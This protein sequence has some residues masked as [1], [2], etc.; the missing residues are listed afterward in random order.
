[1]K[2]IYLQSYFR[3]GY[4]RLMNY[5]YNISNHPKRREIEKR[6]EIIKFFDE[7]GRE[8]TK[9]AFRKSRSTI[10]LWKQKIKESGGK[11]SALAPGDT[12]PKTR[13][14][15]TQTEQTVEFVKNYRLAHPGSDKVTIKPVIDAYCAQLSIPTVSESTIGRIIKKLKD[16]GQIP[17]YYIRTTVNG[18]TG[19]LLFR[20]I[21]KHKIKKLRSK[22]YRPQAPGD[23]IQIDAISFFKDGIK[24]Y[25]IC[26]LDI[27]SRFAFAYLYN[28]LSSVS[29]KDFVE[30][31][32][33]VAPF[34][35]R[36]VQTDNGSEF[37]KYF[38]KYLSDRNITHYWN[39][40]K[41]PK[42]NAFVERFNGVIQKQYIGWHLGDIEDTNAFNKGLME[43][44]IWYNT[45]KVH[46]AIGKQPPLRYFINTFVSPQ[47]S[48]MLWTVT[49]AAAAEIHR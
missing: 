41:Y 9:Q 6:L 33:D 25:C 17:D 20:R 39:Y 10:F 31:I 22:R 27:V 48:N 26:A 3:S 35:V 19:K 37:H 18:A 8:A 28:T 45:E 40:P 44:L 15:R 5:I 36:A 47:K 29:A 11:L 49:R 14:K 46:R 1:M 21:G 12:T 43:Y 2:Q 23:L 13:V 30:K 24:R 38:D 34:A 16:E 42:G 7:F 32:E 4:H